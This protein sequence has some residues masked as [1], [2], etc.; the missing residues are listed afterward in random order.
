MKIAIVTG[1]SS[2][3]GREAVIQLA[4]RFGGLGEI[5]VIARREERLE[6]LRRRVPVP[7]RVLALD[8]TEEDSLDVL[9]WELK[10][11]MPEVKLLVH[12]AGY[13]RPGKVG[14]AERLGE[15]GMVRLNCEALCAVT[16]MVLPYMSD[17]GRILLFASAAGFVP[18]PEFAV[19]AATKAFVISYGRALGRELK[20]R[21][22]TVT[23]VCPGPVDTEF[24]GGTDWK[25]KLPVYKKL[26]M[27][28]PERV[29][30]K[31]IRDSMMGKEMSVYGLPMKAFRLLCKLVPHA[32]ILYGAEQ[33]AKPDQRKG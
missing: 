18:Q 33:L 16:H 20:F 25:E 23:S 28:R 2:G 29:V 30:R 27:A 3:M 31:A 21:D 9:T 4:D 17:H 6:E 1:A 26:T 10:H 19:Y 32:L 5:W 22:I 15:T 14:S 13:G 12:A 7:L 11:Q 24:F 8:L